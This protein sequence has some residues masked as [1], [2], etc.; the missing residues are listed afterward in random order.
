M[1][2]RAVNYLIDAMFWQRLPRSDDGLSVVD[3]TV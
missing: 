3:L 1:V 2:N